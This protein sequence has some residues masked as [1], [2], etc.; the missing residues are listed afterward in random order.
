MPTLKIFNKTT[1]IKQDGTT[2]RGDKS[3]LLK[4]RHKDMKSCLSGMMKRACK[5]LPNSNIPVGDARDSK[6]VLLISSLVLVRQGIFPR[7][8]SG[9]SWGLYT[10]RHCPKCSKH[11]DGANVRSSKCNGG[12]TIAHKPRKE[13][14]ILGR[15]QNESWF[16]HLPENGEDPSNQA[17]NAWQPD[18][19][20][21]GVEPNPGPRE[22]RIK[23]LCLNTQGSNGAWNCLNQLDSQ[24]V[25]LV[26]LQEV[27]MSERD[28]RHFCDKACRKG[29][30]AYHVLGAHSTRAGDDARVGGVVTLVSTC[31]KSTAW[32]ANFGEG[33]HALCTQVGAVTVMNC[34]ARHHEERNTF[35]QNVFEWTQAQERM[36]FLWRRL[37]CGAR[38]ALV[39]QGANLN[40]P[41]DGLGSRWGQKRIIDYLISTTQHE[42]VVTA[43]PEKWSDHRAVEFEWSIRKRPICSN[44]SRV[45]FIFQKTWKMKGAGLNCW[46]LNGQITSHLGNGFVKSS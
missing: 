35:L 25:Q 37:E 43:R 31:C 46:K 22:V 11:G 42:P 16:A 23:G 33:G 29:W 34:C 21:E 9:W 28:V 4:L 39:S 10:L 15:P 3:A 5:T 19:T 2:L 32:K 38:I 7:A 41:Q 20:E 26:L 40:Y 24:T 8:V 12:R 1:E 45:T 27:N 13:P 14:I 18:L 17:E 30:A 6:V 36:P 44:W